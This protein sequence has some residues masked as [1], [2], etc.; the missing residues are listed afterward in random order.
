MLTCIEPVVQ[1][2]LTYLLHVIHSIHICVRTTKC[3]KRFYI[4]TKLFSFYSCF[5]NL[6]CTVVTKFYNRF[7]YIVFKSVYKNKNVKINEKIKVLQ[8]I[9]NYLNK[10]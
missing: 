4:C 2:T 3:F 10:I 9:Y 1:V 8:M 6:K 7:E 5:L